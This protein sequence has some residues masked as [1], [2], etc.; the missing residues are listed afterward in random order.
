[1]RETCANYPTITFSIIN[2]KLEFGRDICISLPDSDFIDAII[3][4]VSSVAHL[5]LQVVIKQ[6]VLDIGNYVVD[7]AHSTPN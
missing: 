7:I 2:K 5:K 3:S 1:M 6:K 4:T